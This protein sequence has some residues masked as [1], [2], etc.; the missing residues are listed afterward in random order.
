MLPNMKN[1]SDL[2]ATERSLAITISLVPVIGSQSPQVTV[3][4]NQDTW[5]DACL[6]KTST[7]TGRTAL[8]QPLRI[9]ITM[10]GKIYDVAQETAVKLMSVCVDG[11]EFIPNWT[12]LA[13]YDNEHGLPGPTSYIGINGHWI[14]DIPEPF[15]VWL[16][17]V[18]G[19]GWLLK[20]AV[21]K[22]Q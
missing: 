16:H 11:F 3:T 1:F 8:L 21:I 13:V 6:H 22:S 12:H 18:T 17:R 10:K 20:P 9:V 5:F 4:V 19:Q 7:L 2:L 15:H 14:L